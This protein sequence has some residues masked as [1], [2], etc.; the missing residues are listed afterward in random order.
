MT[1]TTQ[2]LTPA[3]CDLRDF[4]FMPIEV[5]RLFNSEF[6]AL[7]NDSAWRA[8]VTLWLKAW[9]QVPAASLPDDDV[10]LARLAELGRDTKTFR[11]IRAAAL[12][13]WVKASDGRLYHP[14]VAEKALEAWLEKLRQRVSSAAGNAKRWGQDADITA[15]EDSISRAAAMLVALAPQSK[16]LTKLARRQSRSA[17]SGNPTGNAGGTPDVI[18]PGSQETG[19]G[20]G[21]KEEENPPTPLRPVEAAEPKRYEFEGRT[22]R[23]NRR[24]FDQWSASY[25]AIPD[26]RA[27]LQSLDDWLQGETVPEAKRKN[28]FQTV[29]ALLGKKHAER[30]PAKEAQA[31]AD[32]AF[33]KRYPP[34]RLPE[35]EWRAIM[36]DEDFERRRGQ[37]LIADEPRRA[38]Q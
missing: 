6:H 15:I 21:N 10:A 33:D 25:H 18:P 38:V 13:G 2:P 5:V 36:G 22:I 1:E 19:T 29:S 23:L 26:L 30:L 9:H 35:S 12:R 17:S 8:G 14:V 31:T 37:L 16:A 32:A 3:D 11:K 34:Q 24:D 4:A 28:W 27:E 20:T 7:A